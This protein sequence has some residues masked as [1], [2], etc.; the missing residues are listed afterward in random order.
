MNWK[1]DHFDW[2]YNV[3]SI[4][5]TDHWKQKPFALNYDW[6]DDL[7]LE[8]EFDAQSYVRELTSRLIEIEDD[9]AEGVVVA[10]LRSRGYRVVNEEA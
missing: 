10:W 4:P 6:S 3:T 7:K 1:H 2:D 8:Y 9:V 5:K